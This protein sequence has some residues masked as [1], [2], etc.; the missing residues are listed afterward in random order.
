MPELPELQLYDVIGDEGFT[1]LA[2]NF[3]RLVR[4]DDLLGPM[5]PQQDFEGAERRLKQFL[6][7]RFGGPDDYIQHRGHPR[8]RMRHAPFAIDSRARDR[9]M[10]LMTQAIDQTNL[11]QTAADRLREFF[12]VVS[13]F[14][15]NRS[16]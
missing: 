1:R 11:D 3:Y 13:T 15:I 4:E 2:A 6:V 7:F 5:Y 10:Q 9:W 8:L 16:D 14:L 12:D